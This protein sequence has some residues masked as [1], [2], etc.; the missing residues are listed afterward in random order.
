MPSISVPNYGTAAWKELQAKR[1]KYYKQPAKNKLT[2]NFKVDEFYTHDGS[3]PPIVAEKAMIKLCDGYLEPMRE[4]F[5]T[6]LILSGYRH[7]AYNR[8]I[9]GA[10]F[11]QHVYEQSFDSVAADV[12]FRKGTPAQ[13]AAYARG[14]RG[15]M[16]GNGG[17]GRYD[18]S[19]FVHV[20]NRG[21]KADWSG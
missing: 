5:G 20:D 18:R 16:G 19:G 7:E 6:C 10:R 15:K 13:W 17:V 11:S 1:R 9:G 12:R 4:K 21:W 8:D 14:L 2:A 3:C